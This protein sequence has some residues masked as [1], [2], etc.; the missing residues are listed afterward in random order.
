MVIV[1]KHNGY[2]FKSNENAVLLAT[3]I[4]HHIIVLLKQ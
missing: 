3:G 1:M 4:T 2:P